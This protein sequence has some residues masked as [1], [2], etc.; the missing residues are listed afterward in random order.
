MKFCEAMMG[1]DM[2]GFHS[3]SIFR[4]D[5]RDVSGSMELYDPTGVLTARKGPYLPPECA[6]AVEIRE[7]W[8][9][10]GS[11]GPFLPTSRVLCDV[12]TRRLDSGKRVGLP[13][14]YYRT[15]VSKTAHDVENPDNPENI[16]NY[17]DNH[18]LLGLG[19]PGKPGKQHPLYADPKIFYEMTR[20][21][22]V[23][24]KSVPCNANSFILISAGYDGL[25]G[26]KDDVMDFER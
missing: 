22:K 18:A 8:T 7:I 4:A 6:D 2:E 11:R 25:Y 5:G 14:L 12:Y 15:D 1:Q 23:K 16:Y 13:V 19:V 20:D 17:K 26:T 9:G 21:K 24:G 3:N 10:T